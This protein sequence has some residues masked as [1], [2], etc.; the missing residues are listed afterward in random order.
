MHMT[1]V[2]VSPPDNVPAHSAS[3]K[4]GVLRCLRVEEDRDMFRCSECGKMQSSGS[5]MVWVP[6]RIRLG[7]DPWAVREVARREAYNGHSS[8][9]CLKCAKKLGSDAPKETTNE[10]APWWKRFANRYL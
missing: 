3:E 9:W 1:F 2:E 5:A 8:E 6:D 4:Y 7:D 10:T